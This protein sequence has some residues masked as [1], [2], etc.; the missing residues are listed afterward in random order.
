VDCPDDTAEACYLGEC[1][2]QDLPPEDCSGAGGT[3][4]GPGTDC[5]TDPPVPPDCSITAPVSVPPGTTGHVASVPPPPG[6][7]ALYDWSVTGQ[8]EIT[9]PPPYGHQITFRAFDYDGDEAVIDISVT[10]TDWLTG[11]SCD[12]MVVVLIDST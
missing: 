9:S 10:V 8:G 12:G 4:Q 3:P 2:C 1:E 11:C 6:Q 7:Y 5:Q